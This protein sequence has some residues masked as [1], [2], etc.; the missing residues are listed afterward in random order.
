MLLLVI[1]SSQPGISISI[2]IG[3]IFVPNYRFA[4]IG[5]GFEL[6]YRY[7][8]AMLANYTFSTVRHGVLNRIGFRI[9][10][11]QPGRGRTYTASRSVIPPK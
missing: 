3:K 2:A 6:W 1:E 11:E 4:T 9:R 8:E 7:V 5:V 10:S